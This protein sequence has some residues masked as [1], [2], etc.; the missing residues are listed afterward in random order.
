ME[1]RNVTDYIRRYYK[2]NDEYPRCLNCGAEIKDANCAAAWVGGGKMNFECMKCWE[3]EL[4]G[5]AY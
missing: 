1:K 4:H 5:A 2:R 3:E